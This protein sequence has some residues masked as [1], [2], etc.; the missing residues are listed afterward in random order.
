MSGCALAAARGGRITGPA[1]SRRAML[2]A[3]L[4]VAAVPAPAARDQGLLALCAEERAAAAA[5]EAFL[6]PWYDFV[7]EKPE[8]VL[9]EAHALCEQWAAAQ[10]RVADTPAATLAG[11]RLKAQVL[12]GALELGWDGK[13]LLRQVE[14]RLAYSLACDLLGMA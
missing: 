13:P 11:L 5:F 7:G 9:Q 8:E 2:A 10:C 1:V 3:P 14:D 12:I 4:A 6:E